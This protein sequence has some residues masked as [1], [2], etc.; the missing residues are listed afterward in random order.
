MKRIIG[1]LLFVGAVAGISFFITTNKKKNDAKETLQN[2]AWK[3]GW[4]QK[5]SNV[6]VGE[7]KTKMAKLFEKENWKQIQ[8][9]TTRSYTI[10]KRPEKGTIVSIIEID[11]SPNSDKNIIRI[12]IV[13]K[14]NSEKMHT[15]W[16][17]VLYRHSDPKPSDIPALLRNAWSWW[18]GRSAY[19]R[20][21]SK[22]DLLD[23]ECFHY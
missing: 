21:I 4:H 13:P 8:Y 9:D 19:T 23:T 12:V 16:A 11:Y 10:G 1:I 14:P 22:P 20:S 3:I 5:F 15:A 17:E 7:V 2:M 6:T 18:V